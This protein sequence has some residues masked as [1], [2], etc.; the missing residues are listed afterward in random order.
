MQRADGP[1]RASVAQLPS[2]LSERPGAPVARASEDTQG[3]LSQSH[4][5]AP[6]TRR[7]GSV[8]ADEIAR[9][10]DRGEAASID[11]AAAIASGV[12][13]PASAPE[14]SDLEQADETGVARIASSVNE[15]D[16][17]IESRIAPFA[18]CRAV[19]RA[20]INQYDSNTANVPLAR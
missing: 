1:D 11:A 18:F 2:S 10:L 12:A 8:D 3:P 9:L 7:A 15:E 4:T 19:F 6:S 5:G 14:E 17:R 13:L 20:L 16:F